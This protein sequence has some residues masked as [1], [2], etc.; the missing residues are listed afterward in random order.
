MICFI[1]FSNLSDILDSVDIGVDDVKDIETIEAKDRKKKDK[2]SNEYVYFF[3]SVYDIC[4]R[5]LDVH[6]YLLDTLCIMLCFLF[7]TFFM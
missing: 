3:L 1:P 7:S 2:S 4:K 5:H 6:I